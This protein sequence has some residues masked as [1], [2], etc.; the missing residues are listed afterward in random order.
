MVLPSN[1]E[2]C[3]LQLRDSCKSPQISPPRPCPRHAHGHHPVLHPRRG[4]SRSSVAVSFA[5]VHP[6]GCPSAIAP[7]FTFTFA[8]SIPSTL[9]TASACAANASFSSIRPMSSSVS[10][11]HLQRLG[12]RIHRPNPHLLRIA[13]RRRKRNQPPIAGI[14]KL[15][16]PL[17][18]HHH[19]RR[20]AIRHLR[21]IPRRHRPVRV[22]HRLQLR[23]RLQRRIRPRPLVHLEDRLDRLRLARPVASIT[24][25]VTGT[26]TISS[27]NRPA[28]IAATAFRCDSSANWSICSRVMP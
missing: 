28:A 8:G 11:S 26:G 1:G 5:P 25:F 22:K 20:R 2:P 9:I 10:P 7:P 13:P 4:I 24:V 19:R 18:R 15:R 27:S 3:P 23:Q 12:H 17:R 14:P 16:R 6:S 21:R